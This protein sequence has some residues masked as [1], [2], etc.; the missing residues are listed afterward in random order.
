MSD[1]RMVRGLFVILFSVVFGGLAVVDRGMVVMFSSFLVVFSSFVVVHRN[2]LFPGEMG[3]T[4][5]IAGSARQSNRILD[6]PRSQL[7]ETGPSRIMAPDENGG[8]WHVRYWR[9]Q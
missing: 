8:A 2:S 7:D 1:V 5:S 6:V 9:R 3:E 4:G